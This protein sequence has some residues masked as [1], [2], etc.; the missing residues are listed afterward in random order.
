MPTFSK[1]FGILLAIILGSGGVIAIFYGLNYL[2]NFLP[3]KWRNRVTPWI[4]LAPALTVLGAYLF[5][6]TLNTVYL[7]FLDQRSE[8]FVG[9]DNYIFAFTNSTM[10]KA[11]SNNILWLVLV[12]SFSIAL[13]LI[14]AVLVDRVSYESFAKALIFLPLAISFVGASVIWRFMYAFRP[15]GTAQIGLL[16]GIIT[17]LGFEPIGWLVERSINNFALIAIMI[18]LQTGFCTI[19]FSA[20]VK[21]IPQ[22]IIEAARMDGA[23]EWQIC[24]KITSPMIKSTM[25]VV[26]T[27]VVIMVL[28]VFDIVWVMTNGNQGT[29]VIAS[30]M[31]K[32]M[33]NSRDFGRGS[34][35]A[36]IL[37]LVIV[38]VMI[39][40][41]R[42]FQ[43]Q[44]QLR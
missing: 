6:P 41:I 4:Y 23:S 8:N 27:T 14:I 19:L 21:G 20:A 2:T 10:L 43:Q 1:I 24:W 34:A 40:N 3:S 30:R 32:E 31:L 13:G 17:S 5:L 37:L 29:E 42:R 36:V 22:D 28:K 12:T 44:E 35:I 7:S 16:N 9:L 25:T 18:W 11:F 39:G 33:F 15:A 38:P 26:A